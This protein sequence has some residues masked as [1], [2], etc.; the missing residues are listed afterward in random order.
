MN[1]LSGH[2]LGAAALVASPA[3][4]Q[5]AVTG[6]VAVDVA[7]TR[8][9]IAVLVC[10]AALSTVA[11]LIGTAP[12]TAGTSPPETDLRGELA[13]AAPARPAQTD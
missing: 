8:Y 6:T 1:M 4:W 7:L 9:L 2:V 5:A 13:D 10:W 12:P 3:L 11:S